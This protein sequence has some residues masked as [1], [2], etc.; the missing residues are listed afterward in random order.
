MLGSH[1]RWKQRACAAICLALGAATLPLV[2]APR[3][4]AETL[5]DPIPGSVPGPA[6][7]SAT[8]GCDLAQ[9]S[10]T[11]GPAGA[12]A[13]GIATV[14]SPPGGAATF[15]ATSSDLYVVNGGATGLGIYSLS[16]ARIT[17]FPL[18]ASITTNRYNGQPVGNNGISQ[19]VIDPSG[20]IFISSY[21]AGN[22][23]ELSPTG[24]V[25]WSADPSGGL[26]TSIF[27]LRS[28]S[29]AW[30]LGVSIAEDSTQS[31]VYTDSGAPAGSVP[32]WESLAA[33]TSTESNGDL[34]VSTG[35]GYVQTWNPTGTEQLSEW[36]SSDLHAAGQYTGGPFSFF[37]PDQAVQGQDGN[38]WAGAGLANITETRPDGV[39]VGNVDPGSSLDLNQH[40]LGWNLADVGGNLYFLTGQPF[41]AG[42]DVVSTISESALEQAISEPHVPL[43]T[44]GWGA[45]LSSGETGNYFPPG[46][47][48]QLQARFD[49][50][51]TTAAP[52]LEL[53]YGIWDAS[54]MIGGTP[55]AFTTIPLPTTASAL[56]SIPLTVPSVDQSPGPY[57]VEANLLDTSSSPP[58]LVAST[59]M[60]FSV[61]A[62]GDRLDFSS[63]PPGAGA[64][65]PS[66]PRGVVLNAQLGLDGLRGSFNLPTF[67]PSCNPLSPS[68]STCGPSALSFANAPQ[69]YFQAAALALEDHVRYWV[70]ITGGV[71]GSAE[72]NLAMALVRGGWWGSDIRA[73][74]NYYDHPPASCSNCAPVTAWEPWNEANN[75]GWPDA[76]SYVS[77]VLE[78]FYSAIKAVDP[79]E[80]VV[81]GSTIGVPTGWWDQLVGA[82]GLSYLDVAAVHP[83]TGNNDTFEEDG[84]EHQ[85]TQLESLLDGKPVWFTEVG[86]WGNGDYDMI[87]QADAVAHAMLW[88][89]VLGIP[90]WN[91]FF[92][93]GLWGN[94]GISFSLVQTSSIGDDY[95]KPAAL[96]TM[97]AANMLADRAVIGQPSLGIPDSYEIDLGPTPGGASDLAA[98]WTDGLST[99]AS[100][101]VSDASGATVPVTVTT[102][103]GASSTYQLQPGVAY[104]LPIAD[105]VSY[106]SYPSS[107]SIAIGATERYG[108][109]L[110]L[111]SAGAT[112]T[113][114]SSNGN[115]PPSAALVDPEMATGYGQGWSSADGDASPW[116]AVQLPSTAT[117]NRVI[118]DTQSLGSTAPG[119][120]DY[121]VSVETNGGPWTPVGSVVGEF[122]NHTEQVSFQPVSAS[123]VR[124]DVAA[125]D[126]GGYDG[127]A[128]PDFWPGNADA[129]AFIHAVQVYAGSDPVG[130]VDGADLA[131]LG[132]SSSSSPPGPSVPTITSVSPDSGSVA[133]GTAVTINGA[134]LSGVTAVSFGTSSGA[135]IGSCSA[136]SCRV[137]TPPHPPGAVPVTVAAPAGSASSSF[138]FDA[139]PALPAPVVGAAFDAATG[140]YWLVTAA[141]NVYG[142]HAPW[143]GSMA[144]R[145]L[146]APVVGMAY[147]AA[148]GGY[149]LVTA[150]GNVYGFHAPWWG[151]MAG[152][153]LPA[154]VVG[155]NGY[156]AGYQLATSRGNVYAFA[157]AW[158]GSAAAVDL[159][160]PV[161]SIGRDAGGYALTTSAANLYNEGAAFRG[162]MA[163]ERPAGPVVS[164]VG[165]L[166]TGGYWQITA[167]GNVYGFDA[168]WY[169]S[170]AAGQS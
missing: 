77:D 46:S 111:G 15:A 10:S 155:L 114:S 13:P 107:D 126:Y 125:V 106:L 104:D 41:N 142:F 50:W 45:G 75:T 5:S 102:Q 146:P 19:P 138:R 96:A 48:V 139:P 43:D 88:Q 73:I 160:A 144:G 31:S 61:G 123:A 85:V 99:A 6:A 112:A 60:P 37:Y 133:G 159:P 64:G 55:P 145:A 71:T 32:L 38:I 168:P 117:I 153:A 163:A 89:R 56:G 1:R 149:W 118:V 36:G 74:V 86:W 47:D 116:L 44:L 95:V 120:R 93:E 165:D 129:T 49:P 113:A 2:L 161:T 42:S 78:P 97:T 57:Q 148:T 90:V 7:V 108:A 115:N 81:G 39:L 9:I 136:T 127:G 157:A 141:G 91:Y 150:A 101:T 124:I 130:V 152:R 12:A 84:V 80:T 8:P 119:L 66:D 79:S 103:F 110:A 26:P 11:V 27:A 122:R 35:T 59:C 154:P 109:D 18:P 33:Y 67:L 68:A 58:T 169:G 23:V 51:W 22:V 29:G 14:V 92:D 167:K 128:I 166:R 87:Q 3:A 20:N 25:L 100:L 137:V 121:T 52:H 140:G 40:A 94:D 151:S 158:R 69:S 147:D 135:R 143:W 21:Y 65:G 62:P 17:S 16:G 132:G 131:P 82:G 164:V 156:G 54:D 170:P 70:Q 162:S 4:G 34:L 83:Y 53:S 76:A 24:S 134:N 30:E 72:G 98:V 28:P 63:L 105:Q